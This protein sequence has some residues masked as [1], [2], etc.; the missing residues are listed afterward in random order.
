M[1]DGFIVIPE[2]FDTKTFKND[3]NELHP[4]KINFTTEEWKL[5]SEHKEVLNFLDF[6]I[7]TDIY[8][9]DTNPYD[10]LNFHSF[11]QK[12]DGIKFRLKE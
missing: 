12:R 9:K 6:E 4:T 1:D 11:G 2:N 5:T 7:Q 3:S 8:Y 10:D